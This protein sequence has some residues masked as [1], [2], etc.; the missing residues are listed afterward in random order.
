MGAGLSSRTGPPAHAR[1]RWTKTCPQRAPTSVL[2]SPR[3]ARECTAGRHSPPCGAA[4]L[5]RKSMNGTG[6]RACSAEGDLRS[7]ARR[8]SED[9]R[10]RH[11]AFTPQAPPHP[12]QRHP[13]TPPSV[14]EA[15][16]PAT[17]PRV[18]QI[19]SR[20][21]RSPAPA[22]CPSSLYRTTRARCSRRFFSTPTPSQLP[23]YFSTPTSAQHLSASDQVH[24]WCSKSAA[25]ARLPKGGPPPS[26]ASSL[27]WPSSPRKPDLASRQIIRPL[28]LTAFSTRNTVS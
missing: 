4:N 8:R 1:M 18:V 21:P 28:G 15:F 11:A 24:R 16:R 12:R 5:A 9:P 20:P 23:S 2:A 25:Q 19:N 22:C 7:L 10:R 27:Q 14:S 17:T 6:G 26:R 13:Q 3:T